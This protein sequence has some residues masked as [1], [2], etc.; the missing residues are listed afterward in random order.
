MEILSALQGRPQSSQ[1]SLEA[2][3]IGHLPIGYC[4][5]EIVFQVLFMEIGRCIIDV[6]YEPNSA[7]RITTLIFLEALSEPL[8]EVKILLTYKK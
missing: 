2:E 7:L 8:I 3:Q 6:L 5:V 1:A 4:V